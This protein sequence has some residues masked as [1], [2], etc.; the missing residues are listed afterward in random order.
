MTILLVVLVNFS[1]I[2][3]QI[4]KAGGSEEIGPYDYLFKIP[5][6]TQTLVFSPKN[7]TKVHFIS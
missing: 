5:T 4:V 1:R 3:I 7:K 2:Y 6:T